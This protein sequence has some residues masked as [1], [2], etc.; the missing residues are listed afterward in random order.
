M[1]TRR[2]PWLAALLS[3]VVPGLGHLY[4]GYPLAALIAYVV[5]LLSVALMLVV[6]LLTSSPAGILLSFL[7]PLAIYVAIAVHAAVLAARQPAAFELRSYNRWYVYLSVYVMLGLIVT[8]TLQYR[9][10]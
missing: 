2:R 4:V 8:S 3:F 7:T 5:E 10:K 9:L 6:G 1:T